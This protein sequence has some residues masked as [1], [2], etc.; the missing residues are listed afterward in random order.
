[1]SC[2]FPIRSQTAGTPK[3]MNQKEKNPTK[4]RYQQL[5]LLSCEQLWTEEVPRF[6]Q[7]DPQK[8]AREVALVRAVGVVFSESGTA[9]QKE[10]ARQWLLGLL[11]DPEEKIRRYAMTALPK[12]GAGESAEGELLALLQKTSSDREKKFLAQSLEKIGGAATLEAGFGALGRTV[13][14]VEANVT[15]TLHPSTVLLDRA[16]R[17]FKGVRIHLRGRSGLEGIM[18]EEVKEHTRAK[19]TFRMIQ[20]GIGLLEIEPRTAFTLADLFSLRCF[21][22]ASIL[23]GALPPS[24]EPDVEAL[25]RVMTSPLARRVLETFTEG[26][27][28]YRLNFSSQG[29]QRSVVRRLAD[30][31]YALC[32]SLLNDSR[33]APW[34]VDIHQ[35]S[36]GCTVELTPRLRPDPRFAYRQGDVPAASHPPLAACMARLAGRGENEAVWDPF[37]GSGLE[38]IERALRGGVKRMFG[39]DLSAEA[40]ST[41]ETNIEAARLA[42]VRT[43]L[44]CCDFRDFANVKG[45]AANSITLILT[46]PPMGRRVPIPDLRQLIE[47]LFAAAAEVLKPGGRL[48]LANPLPVAPRDSALKLQF[49]QKVDLGGFHCRLEKYVKVLPDA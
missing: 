39:T 36:R 35:T 38:L 26:P 23:L 10:Q 16:L 37:C 12:L 15:R 11:H 44:A 7:A 28:R 21:S 13:Q 8:R 25:A 3:R 1:M 49:H 17:E 2:Y 18:Q 46:N 5:R 47:E 19:G 30:R 45:L 34:Q 43:T 29:H 24:R 6:D 20:S 33:E 41:T 40:I 31:V 42:P 22:A 32:P 9:A 27:I 14:K 4:E 48:V